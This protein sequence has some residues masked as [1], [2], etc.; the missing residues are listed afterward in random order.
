MGYLALA[1]DR[2]AAAAIDVIYIYKQ[3]EGSYRQA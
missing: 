2:M 1:S 3:Q